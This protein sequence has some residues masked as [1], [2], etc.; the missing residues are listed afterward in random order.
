MLAEKELVEDKY[1]KIVNAI[2]VIKKSKLLSKESFQEYILKKKKLYYL[3][4][5]YQ[6]WENKSEGIVWPIKKSCD[7]FKVLKYLGKS[8]WDI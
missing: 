2:K 8:K 6:E 5:K 4:Q 7:T 1:G 3:K